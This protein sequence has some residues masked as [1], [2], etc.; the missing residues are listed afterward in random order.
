MITKGPV[1]PPH[2][3]MKPLIMHEHW[4]ILVDVLQARRLILVQQ[5]LTCVPTELT[6]IQGSVQELDNLLNLKVTLIAEEKLRKS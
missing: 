3:Q 6:R 5:L 1:K 2:I 4:D